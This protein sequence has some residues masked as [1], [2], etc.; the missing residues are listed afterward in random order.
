[1]VYIME[2]LL[3]ITMKKNN[4]IHLD[5]CQGFFHYVNNSS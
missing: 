1:M 3:A 4:F 5:Y 2:E